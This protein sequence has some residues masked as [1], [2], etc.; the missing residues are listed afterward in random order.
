MSTT[1][2]PRSRRPRALFAVAA[3]ATTATVLALPAAPATATTARGHALQAPSAPATLPLPAGL[4]PEGIT[5]G[6]GTRFY[7]GS[8]ADGR[9]VTGDVRRSGTR[10]LLPGAPGRS[11]RGFAHDSR[12]GLLWAVGSVGTAAHVWAVSARTGAVVRDVVVPGG[13]FL[14]DVVVTRRAAWVTDS[15]VDRLTR[16]A[17][18]RRGRPAAAGPTFLPLRG[19]WPATAPGA[20]GANGIRSLGQDRLLL[21]NTAVG[22][23]WSVSTRTGTARRIPVVGGPDLVS[24]DGIEQRGRTVWV[25]RGQDAASV[26]QLRLHRTS[27]GWVARYVARLTAPTLD[28]PSTATLVGRSLY[29]VNARFGVASPTTATYAL[30]RLPVSRG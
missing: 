18:D 25:V 26:T 7:V 3:A 24:G 12:S 11:I 10:V 16:I 30:T 6:P 28:V 27:S 8:L 9:I 21:D 2:A 17:L 14:N 29:V 5:S 22:G 23:L 4:Q 19:G 13:G 1:T 20:F 15:S